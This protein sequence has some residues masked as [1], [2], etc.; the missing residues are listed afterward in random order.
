[1]EE[2]PEEAARRDE[3][4]RMYHA[5]KD[6]LS[7]IGDVSTLTVATP[8]P[9]PVDDS[10]IKPSDIQKIASDGFVNCFSLMLCKYSCLLKYYYLRESQNLQT[11]GCICC[12][13]CADSYY[14]LLSMF[15]CFLCNCT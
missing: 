4:L 1:M 14:S 6:A 12:A 7:I 11:G 13:N 15:Y 9:P 3:V 5:T 2:S 8:V 10:W